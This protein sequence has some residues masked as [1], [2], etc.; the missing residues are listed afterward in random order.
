MIFYRDD[1]WWECE[2]ANEEKG[3]LPK[4][5]LKPYIKYSDVMQ[6]EP[7]TP[8][9]P[10]SGKALWGNVKKALTE[11][12]EYLKK[13]T[14]KIIKI[15]ISFFFYMLC[16]KQWTFCFAWFRNSNYCTHFTFI[17]IILDL[18]AL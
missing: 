13:L 10:R 7:T 1:G 2:N 12:S 9:S 11:V 16:G 18:S 14:K 8:V 3:Y 17:Y 15:Y 5:F 4:N 6:E